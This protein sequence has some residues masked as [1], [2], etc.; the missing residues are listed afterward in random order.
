MK[1]HI[2]I[3][4]VSAEPPFERNG[5]G[6]PTIGAAPTLD[7]AQITAWKEMLLTNARARTPSFCFNW[8][9]SLAILIATSENITKYES[10]I[11]IAIISPIRTSTYTQIRSDLTSGSADKLP[12]GVTNHFVSSRARFACVI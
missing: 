4:V 1:K 8:V 7:I 9:L 2:I 3:V 12:S 10:S 5:S 6:N 11:T